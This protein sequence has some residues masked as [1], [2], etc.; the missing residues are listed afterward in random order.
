VGSTLHSLAEVSRD[1]GNLTE[2]ESLVHAAMRIADSTGDTRSLAYSFEALAGLASLRGDSVQALRRLGTAQAIRDRV[3]ARLAPVDQ[4]TLQQVMAGAFAGTSA[5]EQQSAFAEA[6][7][8]PLEDEIRDVLSEAIPV[9]ASG[10]DDDLT[11]WITR[12]ISDD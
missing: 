12:L 10:S 7:T 3:G 11:A 8:I 2:A 6:R 4:D 5:A 1:Q 9:I